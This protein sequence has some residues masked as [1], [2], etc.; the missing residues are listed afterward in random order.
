V[1]DG[2]VQLVELEEETGDDEDVEIPLA[3]SELP[4]AVQQTL[5]EQFPGAQL[6]E[7]ESTLE[8]GHA[9]Y[10]VTALVDGEMIDLTL[11]PD[12]R[13]VATEHEIASTDL[14]QAVLDWVQQHYPNAEI[15]EAAVI[16]RDGQT[17][18]EVVL[19]VGDS[20][21]IEAML[22][23]SEAT[24]ETPQPSPAEDPLVAAPQLETEAETA[25]TEDAAESEIAAPTED[26]QLLAA[27][28][29]TVVSAGPVEQ[30]ASP[31]PD[32]APQESDGPL[33]TALAA[34]AG[35]F[36]NNAAI[37]TDAI[38]ALT[39]A[40]AQP[41]ALLPAIAG[42]LHDAL[43]LDVATLV[44]QRLREILNQIDELADGALN[45]AP[46]T[47]AAARL[48]LIVTLAG[49]AHLVALNLRLRRN[50]S[51][52]AIVPITANS[53]WSWVLGTTTTTRK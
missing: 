48:A 20:A 7:A 5:N 47:I 19:D 18:Y 12:G 14:P 52:P 39:A 42:A 15:D 9:E 44:E 17:N 6:I 28:A 33:A 13:I 21:Q 24:N 49:A 26:E 32:N 30:A 22:R 29:Q 45:D 51:A 43:P 36:S 11:A 46:A 1:V 41:R 37:T 8:N 31:P 16:V 53:T 27:E 38:E 35:V 4:D 3:P 2:A 10:D 50:R 40:A 23:V 34:V 25:P